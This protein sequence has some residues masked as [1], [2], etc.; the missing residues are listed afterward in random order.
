MLCEF[1]CGQEAHFQL[2][3]GKWCCCKS[4]NSC[5]INREKNRLGILNS[6]KHTHENY[7]LRY[8]NMSDESKRKMKWN[9][10]LTKNTSPSVKKIGEVLSNKRKLGL[11]KVSSGFAS[12]PEKETNR[13]RKI[14]EARIR[15]LEKSSHINWLSLSNGLKVQG[16]WEYNVGEILLKLNYSLSRPRINFDNTHTYTPDFYLNNENVYIEVKG[17]YLI[18][19]LLNIKKCKGNIQT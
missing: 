13:R 17:G 6:P 4:H 2:K 9:K 16:L 3:S 18:G 8:K 11:I 7:V 12:T 5:P 15:Y 1:G 19:I 14:S 10:G